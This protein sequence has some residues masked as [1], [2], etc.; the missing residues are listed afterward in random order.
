MSAWAKPGVKCVCVKWDE[1]AAWAADAFGV[2]PLTL[3]QTY[4][5]RDCVD[6]PGGLGLLLVGINNAGN[7]LFDFEMAYKAVRFRPLVSQSK[8]VAIFRKLLVPEGA[9]A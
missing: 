3:N 2:A 4:T 9:D 1:E 5:I 6:R 7:P 8:D